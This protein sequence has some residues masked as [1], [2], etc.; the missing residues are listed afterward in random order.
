ML[1]VMIYFSAIC[2][3]DEGKCTLGE[4]KVGRCGQKGW[5][6]SAIVSGSIWHCGLVLNLVSCK[7]TAHSI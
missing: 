1:D 4:Y 7:H 2:H 6:E 3:R 5:S